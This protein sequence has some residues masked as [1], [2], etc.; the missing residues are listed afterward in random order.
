MESKPKDISPEI[1][2][3]FEK[4]KLRPGMYF[5]SQTIYHLRNYIWGMQNALSLFYKQDEIPVVIPEDFKDFIDERYN[6]EENRGGPMDSFYKVLELEGFNEETALFRWFEILDEY[7]VSLGYEP[8]GCKGKWPG[9]IG[10]TK[11][12]E[13]PFNN[14]HIASIVVGNEDVKVSFQ[15]DEEKVR[16]KIAILFRNVESIESKQPIC[17]RIGTFTETANDNDTVKYAFRAADTD[18]VVCS[19][20]AE[21]MDVYYRARSI[22][23]DIALHNIDY[24]FVGD[25]CDPA[26][27]NM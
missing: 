16:R 19:I 17:G 20:T 4:L 1:R 9:N 22:S 27:Y 7:L 3:F 2:E 24:T 6:D 10:L 21:K 8:I 18:E 25:Q 12:D 15:T 23:L 13:L 11:L 5:G 14:G 26:I